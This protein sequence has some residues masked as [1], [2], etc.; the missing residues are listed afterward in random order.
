ML[1]SVR[2]LFSIQL[3]LIGATV[4]AF[5]A[6]L[7][8]VPAAYALSRYRFRGREVVDTMLEFPSSYPRRRWERFS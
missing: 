5:L 4:A 2:T 1:T 7:L 3:S 6:I 8:A